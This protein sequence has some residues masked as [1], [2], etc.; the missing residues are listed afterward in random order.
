MTIES[1]IIEY[2]RTAG[3][4]TSR[5]VHRKLHL[6]NSASTTTILKKMADKGILIRRESHQRG[7]TYEYHLAEVSE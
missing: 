6:F 1:R 7:F 5:Q 4:F 2:A 3:W